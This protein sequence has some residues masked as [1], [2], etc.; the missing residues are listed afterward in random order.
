MKI[1]PT[2]RFL[3]VAMCLCM[4]FSLF[5]CAEDTTTI[6][7]APAT[8]AP[9]EEKTEEKT[10]AP[11]SEKTE[12]PTDEPTEAPGCTHEEVAIEGKAAT[13]TEAGLT[14]G[15]K[16]AKCDEIL[17]PQEEIPATG[18]KLDAG[19]PN[20]NVACGEKAT[21][22]YKCENCDYTETQEGAVVEHDLEATVTTAATCTEKGKQTVTCKR[23]GC[24]YS[25]EEEIAAL[26]HTEETVAGKAATCTDKGL[27]DGKKCTVCEATTVEQTEIDALGHAK[28]DVAYMAPTT[29]EEGCVAHKACER[30][31][32]VWTTEDEATTADALSIPVITYATNYYFGFEELKN[33]KANSWASPDSAETILAT[34]RTY[35]R[36]QRTKL[37]KD[38]SVYFLDLPEIPTVAS[39]QYLVVKYR[40]NEPYS[41]GF[42]KTVLG[43]LDGNDTFSFPINGDE[44]WHL[45]IIDLSKANT[46]T[47]TA[48]DDGK[49]Y[50]RVIRIDVLDDERES[51]YFDI[52]FAALTDDLSKVASILSESDTELCSHM[53][54]ANATYTDKGENH[55][56]NCSICA[57]ELEFEHSLSGI[58]TWNAETKTYTGKCACGKD[59]TSDVIHMTEAR[60]TND[61]ANGFTITQEDGFVRYTVKEAKSDDHYFYP[62]MA[63][64][65]VTG[66]YMIIKYR[67][68][69]NNKDAITR[70]FYIGSAMSEYGAAKGGT[71]GDG[72]GNKGW[73]NFIGDG[74]W[75]YY[76]ISVDTS[77][78]KQ[79]IANDDGTYSFKYARLGFTPAATDGSC[80]MDIEYLAFVDNVEAAEYFAFT[81]ETTPV[82]KVNFDQSNCKITG[83]EG[84]IL[85]KSVQGTH[86]E[87]D[88]TGKTL[89][90]PTSLNLGGWCV[91]PGGCKAYKINVIKID[92]AALVEKDM[93]DWITPGDCEVD[94]GIT[95]VGTGAGWSTDCRFGATTGGSKPVDLS[96]YAGHTIDFEIVVETNYGQSFKW[97]TFTNVVVPEAAAE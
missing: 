31:D 57:K 29:A 93:F 45:A 42:A 32:A 53:V 47:F 7:D 18:H 35:V 86:L 61:S 1:T 48:A 77:A 25:A 81:K 9:T 62:L 72:S 16:C 58:P 84:S 74:E 95:K 20:A 39:G 49:Y 27:T 80:Y 21:V 63:G 79:F 44:A 64:S 87:V 28:K 50:T 60:A 43:T 70:T 85:E 17:V 5:A 36:Y 78:N 2:L 41:A 92:G 37:G 24:T 71:A 94:N 52:A 69:N 88:M 10:E 19:T 30:C 46:K 56:T 6:T 68:V 90:S 26:G 96:A 65:A 13:C 34:D 73:G 67:L 22:T 82:H 97:A 4:V 14:E 91:T 55:V 89:T 76:I 38:N 15:K 12:A 83:T 59:M 40:T 66:N 8:N 11:T 3:L 23:E 75:H 51:G 33:R 54:G